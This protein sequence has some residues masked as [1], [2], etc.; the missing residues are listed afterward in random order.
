MA[1]KIKYMSDFISDLVD[2]T[3][4]IRKLTLERDKE[5]EANHNNAARNLLIQINQLS[6]KCNWV[7]RK[8][9]EKLYGNS[10]FQITFTVGGETHHGM[11]VAISKSEVIDLYK[12]VSQYWQQEIKI[13]EI[14][15]I[16]PF[17]SDHKSIFI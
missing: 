8:I 14:K 9:K 1:T 16:H 10:I 7:I 3:Y 12:V 15:E 17:I 5:L 2:I 11:I 13:L 6:K 4:S